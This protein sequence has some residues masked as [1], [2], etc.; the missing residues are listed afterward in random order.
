M[1]QNSKQ[2]TAILSYLGRPQLVDGR[3]NGDPGLQT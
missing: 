1:V 2:Q 3:E